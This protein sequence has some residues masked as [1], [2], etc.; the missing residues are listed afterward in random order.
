MSSIDDYDVGQLIGRGG[1]AEVYRARER[2]SNKE[3]AI[4]IT[5]KAKMVE[6]KM[7]NRIYN[8]IEIHS[9]MENKNIIQLFDSFEDNE[10][11]YM[12]LELCHYGNLFR[13]LKT[14]GP[15]NEFKAILIIKELLQALDYIHNKGVIH[16]DLK[17]SNILLCHNN[18]DNNN[19]YNKVH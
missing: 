16:R 14:S 6:S 12:V 5:N 8:E 13:F 1:F 19:N 2:F 17:L 9:K 11:V 3:I 15:L 10:Y 4:K 7:I 18:I